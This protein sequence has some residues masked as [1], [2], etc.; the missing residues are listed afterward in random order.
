MKKWIVAA[1]FA[2]FG[3]T[4]TAYAVQSCCDSNQPC[5]EEPA[6]CCND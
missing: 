1:L 4:G 6:D 5:C 2:V 3:L